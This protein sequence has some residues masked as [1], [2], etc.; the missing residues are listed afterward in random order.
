M[1]KVNFKIVTKPEY[2]FELTLDQHEAEAFKLYLGNSS[3]VDVANMMEQS[4]NDTDVII[5]NN[6]LS[7]MYRA[8]DD[9]L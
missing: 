6:M 8:L 1:A 7:G 9:N 2:G 3:K 5:V 4:S